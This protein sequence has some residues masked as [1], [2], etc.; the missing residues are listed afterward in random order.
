MLDNKQAEP[1]NKQRK[2]ARKAAKKAAEEVLK[3]AAEEAAE[4]VP[5]RTSL[6]TDE[7]TSKEALEEM[8][9]RQAVQR[10]GE[11]QA[12]GQTSAGWE[13][14]EHGQRGV[15]SDHECL[16]PSADGQHA[17]DQGFNSATAPGFQPTPGATGIEARESLPTTDP[18]EFNPLE[19]NTVPLYPDPTYRAATEE[20]TLPP[21]H[22]QQMHKSGWQAQGDMTTQLLRQWSAQPQVPGAGTN[23]E[24]AVPG[25]G[26]HSAGTPIY[27]PEFRAE[28]SK[29]TFPE[30]CTVQPTRY[31]FTDGNAGAGPN[32]HGGTQRQQP[33]MGQQ[34]QPHGDQQQQNSSSQEHHHG[35]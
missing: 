27:S 7:K 1:N 15:A 3:K 8:V 5:Q 17:H 16:T 19:V 30:L 31:T 25:A 23:F 2:A 35:G 13:Q 26:Q 20:Q 10:A 34:R 33:S 18:F 28:M 29:D 22:L 12:A 14:T 6:A 21:G 24:H 11:M 4:E 32:R 9:Q